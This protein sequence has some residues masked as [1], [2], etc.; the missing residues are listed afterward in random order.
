MELNQVTTLHLIE[1]VEAVRVFEG[2]K[3]RIPDDLKNTHP[4]SAFA[5]WTYYM[6]THHEPEG[7]S[8]AYCQMFDGQ[9][10]TGDQLRSVFPDHQWDGVDIYPNVHKTLWGIDSTC[11]CLLIRD[12]EDFELPYHDRWTRLGVDWT[13][14][15]EPE[16]EP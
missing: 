3:N 7:D 11:S 10:F 9:T 1:A 14:G 12:P 4:Y 5:S 13:K 16:V 2:A 6:R 8:C 15:P